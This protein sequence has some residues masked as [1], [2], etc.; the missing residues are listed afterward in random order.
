M[1][2]AGPFLDHAPFPIREEDATFL[3]E[4][5]EVL[6]LRLRDKRTV[7]ISNLDQLH[8]TAASLATAITQ[9]RFLLIYRRGKDLVRESLT[10][11]LVAMAQDDFANRLA[12]VTKDFTE[13]PAVQP[14][15]VM[16]NESGF[17]IPR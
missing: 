1:G 14:K 2:V 16:D 11:P 7:D 5:D 10:I 9:G 13:A 4:P 3:L 15:Q 8:S 6:S 17:P 12:L